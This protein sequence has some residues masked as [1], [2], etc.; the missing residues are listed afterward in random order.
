M[1][2]KRRH[3][4]TTNLGAEAACQFEAGKFQAMFRGLDAGG[5]IR[6]FDE[7]MLWRFSKCSH[8]LADRLT[9]AK[10]WDRAACGVKIRRRR[11]DAQ[12]P[13]DR[14]E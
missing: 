2:S 4:I 14:R 10:N 7:V 12:M 8:Q 11:V 13:I 6:H 9:L 5:L 3:D 1:D